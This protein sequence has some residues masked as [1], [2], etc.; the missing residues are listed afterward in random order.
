MKRLS[1]LFSGPKTSF[2]ILS[3]LHLDHDSQYLSFHI[4]ATAPYLILAGNIGR[5]LDYEAYLS[6]FIRRCNLYERVFLVLGSL[7][8]HSISIASGFELAA[9]LQA[10]D[11]LKGKLVILN[12]TR[13]EVPDTNVTILGCTLWSQ[14]P[15]SAEAAVLKKIPEFD[16]H[17]GIRQWGV[18]AHNAAHE[19]DLAW[20]KQEVQSSST[21][22]GTNASSSASPSNYFVV[23]SFA[24]NLREALAPWQVDSPWSS[25][26]GT[27]LLSGNDW[28]GVRKWFCGSTGRSVEFKQY[29]VKVVSNERG[30]VGEEVTGVLSDGLSEKDKKGVFDVTRVVRV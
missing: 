18:A 20:L 9:K 3:D 24:P 16:M 22:A 19:T 23:S 2:Q 27:E 17:T 7:E 15:E 4:P 5:L 21:F 11:R 14:I 12:R 26:Y 28:N 10:E 13:Y 29:G 8:F 1:G 25:A 30:C 6:F